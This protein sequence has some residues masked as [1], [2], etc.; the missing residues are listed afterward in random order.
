MS[1]IVKVFVLPSK[2]HAKRT[3]F[4]KKNK[5]LYLGNSITNYLHE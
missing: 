4:K 5:T 1:Y 3:I 2:L